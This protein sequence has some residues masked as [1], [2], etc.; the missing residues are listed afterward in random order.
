MLEF[1]V[2]T[3]DETPPFRK[4]LKGAIQSIEWKVHI[5]DYSVTNQLPF[6]C[7]VHVD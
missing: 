1:V 4:K 6:R 7:Y 3:K 2:K 5:N